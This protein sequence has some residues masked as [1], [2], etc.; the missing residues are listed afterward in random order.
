M[1]LIGF[2]HGAATLSGRIDLSSAIQYSNDPSRLSDAELRHS[3]VSAHHLKRLRASEALA[4]PGSH[5]IIGRSPYPQH[6]AVLP[7]AP[8]VLFYRGDASL[9]QQ[10][11]VAIVGARQCTQR[12]REMAARLAHD[13]ADAGLNIC[14]GLA[15]GIDEA[16]Q[17]AR[18][19]RAIGV[20]GQGWDA[21][22]SRRLKLCISKIL[23]AGGVVIS[24]YTP[25]THATRFTFPQRN[26]IIS[27]VSLA[28]IVVE[29]SERSGSQITARQAL[30][31]GR[32]V[33]AVPGRPHD[34]K[35]A[36]CNRLIAQGAALIQN[37]RDALDFIGYSIQ[38]KSNVTLSCPTQN[39]VLNALKT[40]ATLDHISSATN[41]PIHDLM[42]AL[43]SLELT[44]HI[45]R[46][47]GDRFQLKE[48]P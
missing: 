47:P 17:M 48:T 40:G 16:A 3:G 20:L 14:T 4:Q 29:A 35:S 9:L 6:L 28:T 45:V 33:L 41:D 34:V 36:G 25:H 27:G 10:K 43:Q 13:M 21:P 26:R 42:V 1:S 22:M 23:D 39:R 7:F 18:P 5:L 37:S 31:Q 24:E 12:G 19:D 15:Y 30:E 8:A 2:W 32:D 38:P 46:L 11:S 44:G